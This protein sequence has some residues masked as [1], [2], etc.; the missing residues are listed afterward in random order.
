MI[1]EGP[2]Y[3]GARTSVH[4]FD[5]IGIDGEDIQAYGRV[6]CRITVGKK[7]H[8]DSNLSRIPSLVFEL[9]DEVVFLNF[10]ENRQLW[11]DH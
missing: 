10:L 5:D 11:F 3:C 1:R 9:L 4:V 6:R 2:L 7:K 8:G